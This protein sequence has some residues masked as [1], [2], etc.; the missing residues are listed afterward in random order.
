MR[1]DRV[2]ITDPEGSVTYARLRD[3][4][5]EIARL[6]SDAGVPERVVF[7]GREVMRVSA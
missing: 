3:G 7:L 1:G 6:W 2:A 4:A 5:R